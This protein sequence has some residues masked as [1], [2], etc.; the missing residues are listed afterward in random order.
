M[1]VFISEPLIENYHHL[2]KLV[3]LAKD[4]ENIM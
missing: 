3:P 4:I 1:S 2:F